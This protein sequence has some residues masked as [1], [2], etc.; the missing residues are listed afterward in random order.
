M[1]QL[2]ESVKNDILFKFSNFKFIKKFSD[3]FRVKFHNERSS[4]SLTMHHQQ[5]RDFMIEVV[6]YLEPRFEKKHT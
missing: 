6:Y 2:P 4:Y 1:D 3:W 5:Y